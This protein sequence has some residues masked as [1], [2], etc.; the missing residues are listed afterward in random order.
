MLNESGSFSILMF[1]AGT[2]IMGF[3]IVIINTLSNILAAR[4]E[5]ERNF[6]P[7]FRT[8]DSNSNGLPFVHGIVRS[9]PGHPG[10]KHTQTI[11]KSFIALTTR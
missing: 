3:S 8:S 10:V 6:M 2:F 11:A 1:L 7:F 9:Q 4:K 5:L